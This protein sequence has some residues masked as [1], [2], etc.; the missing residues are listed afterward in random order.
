MEL[1]KKLENL[2]DKNFSSKVKHIRTIPQNLPENKQLFHIIDVLDEA[3]TGGK[4]VAFNRI[5]YGTDKKLHPAKTADGR[6]IECKVSPYQMAVQNGRYYLICSHDNA[7]KLYHYRLSIISNIKVLDE[8]S[9]PFA[10]VS[11][12]K[13]KIDLPLY[14]SERMHMFS[15]E[16]VNVTFRASKSILFG[17]FDWFGLGVS[18]SDETDD[19]VTVQVSSNECDVLYWALQYGKHVEILK[20]Q[21][22]REQVKEAAKSMWEKYHDRC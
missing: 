20:P 12:G 2:S 5:S 9:R 21:N 3:I 16:P 1:I 6:L 13:R 14:L 4:K 7:D 22:L 17:I 19:D 10:E 15:G 8:P 11:K 18:F